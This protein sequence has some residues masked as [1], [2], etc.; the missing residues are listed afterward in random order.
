MLKEMS[1]RTLN[2]LGREIQKGQS[3]RL[4]LEVARL[5]TR[6]KIQIPINIERAKEDGPVL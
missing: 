1:E 6:N 2:I 3:V 5:H 4:E